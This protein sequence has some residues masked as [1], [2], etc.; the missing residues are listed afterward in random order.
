MA[1]R[2]RLSLVLV[3]ALVVGLG[4]ALTP[5]AVVAAG[6]CRASYLVLGPQIDSTGPAST[7][8]FNVFG[9]DF[10]PTVPATLTFSVPVIPWSIGQSGA[11]QT[12]VSSFVIPT[13]DMAGIPTNDIAGSGFKWTFR[14]R[15][16]GVQT[17]GVRIT[18]SGCSASTLVDFSPPATSTPDP[19][20]PGEPSPIVP[21]LLLLAFASSVLVG[22]SWLDHRAR[23]SS[24]RWG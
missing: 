1:P 10:D 9:E 7:D 21:P 15:D 4:V 16:P 2:S 8:W 13:K 18:G 17:I 22:W 24:C 23:A 5:I 3:S 11:G 6:G 14:A 12:A 19:P 20:L